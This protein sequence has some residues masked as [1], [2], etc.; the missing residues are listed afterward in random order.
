MH[1]IIYGVRICF[2]E[3]YPQITHKKNIPSGIFVFINWSRNLHRFFQDFFRIF[4]SKI[5]SSTIYSSHSFMPFIPF[6]HPR[7]LPGSKNVLV[8]LPG[9]LTNK[10]SLFFFA[11][12]SQELSMDSSHH[13]LWDVS[14]NFPWIFIEVIPVCS[15]RYFLVLFGFFF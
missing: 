3:I 14:R 5:I 9:T 1:G 15:F 2:L 8:I 13:S 4:F 12:C 10:L 11:D 7:N 6:I